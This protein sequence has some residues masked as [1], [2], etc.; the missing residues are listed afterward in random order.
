M[1]DPLTALGLAS[2]VAQFVDFGFKV[3]SES[4][5][6]YRSATG[7][8]P[9]NLSLETFVADLSDI[10][11]RLASDDSERPGGTR[12]I[13]NSAIRTWDKSHEDRALRELAAR[14]KTLA[15]EILHILEDLKVKGPNRR[16]ESIRQ[17][18]RSRMKREKIRDMEKRLEQIR[19][20]LNLRLVAMMDVRQS[21]VLSAIDGLMEQ[22]RLMEGQTT[23]ALGHLKSELVGAVE[24]L[25]KKNIDG[26]NLTDLS[27]VMSNLIDET[28]KVAKEQRV[29]NSLNFQH[30]RSRQSDI[31]Q[32]HET[33]FEWIFNGPN[34]ET[35]NKNASS[36]K[37][38]DWLESDSGIYWI[39]GKAGSG[40]STLMKYLCG[41]EVIRKVL[42]QWAGSERLIFASYFFWSAG[43]QVQKS[44]EG[45]LRSLL[46]Q[47]L[48]ECP[49]LIEMAL[50]SWWESDQSVRDLSDAF[51]RIAVQD[52]LPAKFCFFVDGLDEYEGE[53]IDVVRMFQSL[54]NSS[55][56]KICVSSR[57]WNI[58]AESF[59]TNKDRKLLLQDFTRADVKKYVEDV[60][61]GEP[62]FRRLQNRDA[63]AVNVI[64]E[65]VDKAQGV[66]L[67][68]F[69]VVRSLIRGLIDDNDVS[70]LQERLDIL[71][72]QLEEYFRHML[73]KIEDVYQERTAQIF[74]LATNS[75]EPLPTLALECLQRENEDPDY[76]LRA[77]IKIPSD[78]DI[79]SM[80]E[81][82][83]RY[84][85]ACCKDMLEVNI[86]V[87][88]E[89]FFR[90]RVVFLHRS[91][92][93]FLLL[94]EIHDMLR[95]RTSSKFHP[96]TSICRAFLAMIKMLPDGYFEVMSDKNDRTS[97]KDLQQRHNGSQSENIPDAWDEDAPN[98]AS[99]I[100]LP[101]A[102][103]HRDIRPVRQLS[104]FRP[105]LDVIGELMFQVR[106][107]EIH[108]RTSEVSLLDEVDRICSV[109]A[110]LTAKHWTGLEDKRSGFPGDPQKETFLAFAAESR[111]HLF[112][113]QKLDINPNLLRQKKGR[114]LL[115]HVLR[116][117]ERSQYGMV[118]DP[119]WRPTPLDAARDLEMIQLLLTRGADP[120]QRVYVRGGETVWDLFLLHAS[121]RREKYCI[122]QIAELLI[123][124]GAKPDEQV[125][126]I[127]RPLLTTVE[128]RELCNLLAE[129][130][131]YSIWDWIKW[132]SPKPAGK[133]L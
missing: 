19:S 100:Q 112:V 92:K 46:Y 2:S 79:I 104:T 76:A 52:L 124:H 99:S 63:R 32:A 20:Q 113:T 68:V 51:D 109:R 84:L 78:E 37:F 49:E 123:L 111:L 101:S 16:W 121:A 115:D 36:H 60:L 90:Y 13:T 1:L 40:K 4:R 45:L 133:R 10:S 73:E 86:D 77:G 17:A 69:L 105:L 34:S 54:A 26:G 39:A 15:D 88:E 30:M 59:G 129:R 82:L 61:G 58:F 21:A 22:N 48:K 93:D 125:S 67:W 132:K 126:E 5:Q 7:I 127:L 27:A 89:T 29:L 102:Q 75:V 98:S 56:I 72:T 12:F 28:R 53:H 80:N 97:T 3:I 71:P 33:T 25:G 107:I 43:Y 119:L 118:A 23:N 50:P 94:K 96:R 120:N 64:Q 116:P 131:S 85:N 14:S 95:S 6:Q 74:Q 108:D 87:D 130:L 42:G 81:K 44:Q 65:I 128:H 41:H 35:S 55:S 31:K 117:G 66:F 47:I 9:D 83:Q 18:F 62:R 38:M 110:P 8:L 91:V 103:D 122:Y 70:I 57:P 106:M 24:R 11:E 114:P